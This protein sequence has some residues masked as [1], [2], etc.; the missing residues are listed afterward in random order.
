MKELLH[1]FQYLQK[2]YEDN[3]NILLIILKFLLL[4]KDKKRIERILIVKGSSREIADIL[5]QESLELHQRLNYKKILKT[6]QNININASILENFI[7]TIALQK[8]IFKLYAYATPI[9]INLLVFR[10]LGVMPNERVFNPCC[11]LGSWLLSAYNNDYA[12]YGIDVDAK[13]IKIAKLFVELLGFKHCIL[14][15][16][17]FLKMPLKVKE[18][19]KFDKIFCHPPISNHFHLKAPKD[20]LLAPYTKTTPEIPFLD[21]ALQYFKKKAIFIVRSVLLN[22]NIGE[23]LRNVLLESKILE[24]IIELPS[25][26]FPH[27][28][29]DFCLLVVSTENA[30]CLFINAKNFFLKEGKYHKLINIEEILDLYASKQNTLNSHL[31]EYHKIDPSNLKPSFYLESHTQESRVALQQ[32]LKKCYRGARIAPK[33]DSDLI[34]CYDLGVKDFSGFGYTQDFSDYGLKPNDKRLNTLKIKP[35]DILLS[36]RGVLPKI[37][38]IGEHLE[39]KIILPNAGILVLRFKE[40]KMAQAMYFYFLSK[41]GQEILEKLYRENQERV[42]E[43]EINTLALPQEVLDSKWIAKHIESFKELCDYGENIKELEQKIATL[44]ESKP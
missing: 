5:A 19:A 40:A 26:V 9:E 31:L 42:S 4:C 38:I 7:Q 1:I 36:M 43:K 27:Q 23:R 35:F 12:F 13:L 8:T 11:G 2:F 29:G 28:M 14:E 6:F 21:F 33:K 18:S 17:D 16:R 37:A 25:N 41:Q 15:E 20:S 22:K 3:F 39:N 24:A 30:R 34:G 32:L 44:L 10:L